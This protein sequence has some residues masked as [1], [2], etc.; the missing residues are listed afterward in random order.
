VLPAARAE[1]FVSHL[2]VLDALFDV[3][4]ARTRRLVLAG[5]RDWM[6]RRAMLAMIAAARAE[7]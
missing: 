5:Q 3:G 2:S 6:P 1:D 7:P 4:P